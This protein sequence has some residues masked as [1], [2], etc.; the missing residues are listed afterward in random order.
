MICSRPLAID[1]ALGDPRGLTVSEE[2]DDDDLVVLFSLL[3]LTLKGATATRGCDLVLSA[4]ART[5]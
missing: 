2:V 3:P 5:A 4:S 1:P